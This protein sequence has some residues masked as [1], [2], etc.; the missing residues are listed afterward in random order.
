MDIRPW[1]DVAAEDLLAVR[2]GF[3]ASAQ[4]QRR[5]AVEQHGD[6]WFAAVEDGEAVAWIVVKWRGKPT[7]PEY[8]DMEDLF[9]KEPWRG[10]GIGTALV[11][12]VETEAKRRG[13]LKLGLAVN[14]TQNE[15]AKALYERLGY[16]S[17]GGIAY[18]DS[19][20]DGDEDWV[21]DLEKRLGD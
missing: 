14:P 19:V 6:E 17:T 15:R 16:E 5:R 21:I 8:P 7:H 1:R 20:Y 9:V 18:L 2:S 11:R 4:D 13:Y 12:F 10:Q 3:D